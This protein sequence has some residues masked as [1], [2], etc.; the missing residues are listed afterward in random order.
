MDWSG[1][2]DQRIWLPTTS[3]Q[4]RWVDESGPLTGTTAER[5][6]QAAARFA[7]SVPR[8]SKGYDPWTYGD[9]KRLSAALKEEAAR[10]G[11][12][13][14]KVGVLNLAWTNG[15]GEGRFDGGWSSKH[16]EA[17]TPT[18]P[19]ES[20]NFS[21]PL[22]RYFDPGA[23]LHADATPLGGLPRGIREGMPVY[24]AYAAQWGS[25]SHALGLDAIMLR[26]SF[27][28]PIPY[29]R[30]GPWGRVAPS[31]DLIHQAT[32]AVAALVK[33][34][35]LANPDA[36]VMM[37]SNGASAVADWRANGLDLET[38]AKQGYL[39]IWVDQTWAGAW[40][41]VGLRDG[42]FWNSPTQGWTY[43]LGY[44]LTHAAILAD[45]KVRH[46]P[47]VE[48]F[49]AW[50][51]WDIIHSAPERLRWGIWAY[52]HAAVKTPH[53]LKMP[54][55]T[56]IS[57]AN[58]GDRLLSQQDVR[59]LTNNINAAVTDANQTT[60]VFGPTLVYARDAMKWQIEHASPNHDV[61]EW[62][63][64]Q[65]ASVIKW[66]VPILSS[67]RVEWI[68]QVQS[69]LFVLQTPSHLS[70]SH[71]ASLQ[72]LTNSG[73]PVA[74]FGRFEGVDESLLHLAG[75]RAGAASASSPL[76]VCAATSQAPE[77]IKNV[78]TNL[79]VYCRPEAASA[80]ADA[81][82]VYTVQDSPRLTID[83][84][85]GKRIAVWS[86]PDFRSM[87]SLPLS[88]IWGNTGAPYALAAGVLNDLL[89]RN[90]VLHANEIDLRQTMTISAWRTSDGTVRI[91]AGNLEEGLRD[92]ADFTRHATL[93]LP[94]SWP[95][96]GWKNA[97]TGSTI[98]VKDNL[99]KIDLKQAESVLLEPSK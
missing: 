81:R 18:A 32:D 10:R 84:S 5:Q 57:W 8:K 71:L 25:M 34:T 85:G 7:G 74:I 51:D 42:A 80:S 54:A 75:M 89:K 90:T 94:Q 45:T 15:Y 63:D 36:L 73:Q 31:P 70:S 43:Q 35:K 83:T 56:Y 38:V 58:Q 72:K 4:A 33:D 19:V 55:G 91:L 68:P 13:G 93:A 53:G 78:T 87:G 98:S 48:T 23:R 11:I 47:L 40:N 20:G 37:Y 60:E 77:V 76:K 21:P 26:D 64:E 44:M 97:W 69:D 24:E 99:L 66:P 82:I 12:A 29:S 88:Q 52:S 46:Y 30:N 14:Y 67:T 2:L 59:F 49:D 27:G 86:P 16:Q 28:M 62:I 79:N 50:E 39:D 3:G 22:G 96:A 1:N 9:L 92:D 95:G 17:F 41:E 6:K 61:N 65:A